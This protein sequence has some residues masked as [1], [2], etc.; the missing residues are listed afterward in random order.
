MVSR[1]EVLVSII[2]SRSM[3]TPS[4]PA[5]FEIQDLVD[6][7]AQARLLAVNV[8]GE[9][10]VVHTT[11]STRDGRSRHPLARRALADRSSAPRPPGGASVAR[12]GCRA[13]N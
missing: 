9:A 13:S 7:A 5:P 3:P 2:T 1:I 10:G 11:R 6:R 4:P 12:I 8:A